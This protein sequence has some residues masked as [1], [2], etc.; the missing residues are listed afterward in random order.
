M[1]SAC[2]LSIIAA[3]VIAEPA[4]SRAQAELTGIELY[5]WC[6]SPNNGIR[7]GCTS[8]IAGFVEGIVAGQQLVQLPGRLLLCLPPRFNAEQALMT[9][10]KVMHD[11]PDMLSKQA[12]F[13][14]ARALFDSYECKRDESP[15]YDRK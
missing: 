10:L 6:S 14:V 7:D 12:A 15:S 11:D 13:V 4:T 5:Q 8:Y 2:V 9:T 3:S 1:K